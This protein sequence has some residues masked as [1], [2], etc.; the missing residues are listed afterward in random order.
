M[1]RWQAR[2]GG[3]DARNHAKGKGSGRRKEY[4]SRGL[5]VGS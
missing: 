4:M 5:T 3:K 1:D 2:R